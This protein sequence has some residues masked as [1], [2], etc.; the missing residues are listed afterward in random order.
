METLVLLHGTHEKVRENTPSR[1]RVKIDRMKV[2]DLFCGAGGF[3][4]GFRH[5]CV[6]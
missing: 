6:K 2:I 5:V 3:S 4:E 1:I